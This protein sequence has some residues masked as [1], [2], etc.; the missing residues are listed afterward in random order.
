MQGNLSTHELS[1]ASNADLL[2]E[3]LLD[4]WQGHG[5]PCTA[6]TTAAR[7]DGAFRYSH[8]AIRGDRRWVSNLAFIAATF[9]TVAVFILGAHL[10]ELLIASG[11]LAAR[12]IVLGLLLGACASVARRGNERLAI[13]VL[14]MAAFV[15]IL[16]VG[17]PD[18]PP[19]RRWDQAV[20]ILGTLMIAAKALRLFADRLVDAQEARLLLKAAGCR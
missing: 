13:Q 6:L 11:E 20:A 18:Y 4:R 8:G 9:G 2:V 19:L 17:P 12:M 15:G 7:V 1:R 10:A 3:Q 5:A 16:V 14:L